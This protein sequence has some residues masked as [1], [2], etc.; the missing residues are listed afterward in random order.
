MSCRLCCVACAHDRVLHGDGRRSAQRRARAR[1]SSRR[2]LAPA[3][4]CAA[5]L[6]QRWAAPRCLHGGGGAQIALCAAR[7]PALRQRCDADGKRSA[8][9]IHPR[10]CPCGLLSERIFAPFACAAKAAAAHLRLW[11]GSSGAPRRGP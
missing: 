8:S 7:W 5:C 2:P 11:H 1:L 4:V 3:S 6:S 9:F 10:R